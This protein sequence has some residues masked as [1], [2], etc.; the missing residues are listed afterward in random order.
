[1]MSDGSRTIFPNPKFS[2][3]EW[4]RYI[5]L[6]DSIGH[7]F[8]KKMTTS[9]VATSTDA[10]THNPYR[11]VTAQCVYIYIYIYNVLIRFLKT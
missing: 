11:L 10:K 4:L 1:M 3:V 5:H 7:T 9:V 8:V 2:I 6:C